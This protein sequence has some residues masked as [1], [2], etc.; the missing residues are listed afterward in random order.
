MKRL[1]VIL[2]QETYEALERQ[3]KQTRR[4]CAKVAED[5][6]LEG[7]T[8]RD[9]ATRRKKLVADYRAGR[10]DARALLNDL[11]SSQLE[12]LDDEGA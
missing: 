9:A 6:V 4:T 8:R 11:E 1:N 3:A 10:A 7:L 2:N 5:L 12:L